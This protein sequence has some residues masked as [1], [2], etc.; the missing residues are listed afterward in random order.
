MDNKRVKRIL[1]P[2]VFIFFLGIFFL[3]LVFFLFFRLVFFVR[4]FREARGI[5]LLVI[6][7]AFLIGMRFDA[8]VISYLLFPFYM[9]GAFPI[10]GMHKWKIKRAVLYGIMLVVFAF[11][12]FLLLVDV[13]FYREFGSRL[14]LFAV[15]YIDQFG[16]IVDMIWH[17]YPVWAYLIFFLAIVVLFAVIFFRVAGLA[18]GKLAGGGLFGRT[19]FFIL[20][21]ALLF[22]GARGR[23][24]LAPINWGTAYFSRYEYANQLALNGPYTLG[25]SIVREKK[26]NDPRWLSKLVYMPMDEAI[27]ICSNM[28]AT[29]SDSFVEPGV[30]LKRRSL[31]SKVLDIPF[32]PNII[33]ILLESWQARLVGAYGSTLGLTPNFDS[34]AKDGI[35]F[36]N[37]YATGVRT[38]RGL[39]SVLCSFPSQ[40]GLT[41]M[42]KFNAKRAFKSLPKLLKERGYN[43]ILVY[44]GDLKFDNIEGFFRSEGVEKFVGKDD[45][46]PS[47]SLGKWGVP[48]HIVFD[49]ANEE[50]LKFGSKPFLGIIITLSNHPPNLLP[51]SSFMKFG[52]EVKEYKDLNSFYYSDWSLGRFFRMARNERYFK[53]SIFVLV[54]DHGRRSEGMNEM[55]PERFKIAGLIYAPEILKGI[56]P[57]RIEKITSQVDIIPTIMG[58]LG[59]PYIHESWGRDIFSL[60]SLDDGFAIM[61][62]GN[63]LGYIRQ[64]FYFLEY[65]GARY[66]LY[67]LSIDP[68]LKNDISDIEF[69]IVE[70]MRTEARA[71]IQCSVFLTKPTLDNLRFSDER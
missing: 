20:G 30:S 14:N 24:G 32:E 9:L 45:F 26:E 33:V 11:V 21:L 49:R 69:Q 1:P 28:V 36:E 12:L 18:F 67:D 63:K 64:Q 19:L 52:P 60:D 61:I 7:K 27:D 59:K 17:S 58:I 50:F 57:M 23:V 42:K 53:R 22:V 25:W 47:Q 15:E 51:D 44:G 13:E 34:L 41:I 56:A 68:E 65:I 43:T 5:P 31:P 2:D 62:D 46:H 10:F 48:D 4:N 71:Y 40:P 29:K 35:I 70:K 54:A 8:V 16:V 66:Y 38:N 55:A 6:L 3:L 39:V 37:M